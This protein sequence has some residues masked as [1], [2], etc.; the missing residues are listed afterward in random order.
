[1]EAVETKAYSD[2]WDHALMLNDALWDE[3]F[4]SSIADQTRPWAS[5]SENLQANIEGLTDGAGLPIDRYQYHDGGLNASDVQ[6]KFN[7]GD[8]YLRAAEH[9]MVDGAF[10]V[11]ST[12]VNAWYALFKGIRER[13]LVYRDSSGNLNEVDVPEGHIALSRF[14]TPTTDKETTD[15]SSG[16]MR[17]DGELVWSGVRFIDDSQ[18]RLL[19]EKCVE[20]VKRRGPFLNF[21]EFINRRLEESELGLMGALQSAIDYDDTSPEADSINYHHKQSSF[22]RISPG[23][24]G[25]NEYPTPDAVEG[26]RLAGIPGYVIQSDLLKPIANTLQVRD[27]TFRIR[28]YGETLD[29]EGKVIARAWCEAVVQRIPDYLDSTNDAHVAVYSYEGNPEDDSY[30]PGWDGQFVDN[31]ELTELNRRF[32]RQFKIINFRWLDADEI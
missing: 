9:L 7:E 14:D 5:E 22:L 18:L 24:L 3:Y 6:D 15:L 25:D 13:K 10:N 26:S 8:A 16:V 1:M 12:S 17:D 31:A 27:D 4:I 11:N 32:G 20:Q 30:D 23:D 19:A 28:S 2:Y 29:P 21:S